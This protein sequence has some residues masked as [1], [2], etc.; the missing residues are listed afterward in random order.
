ML[1]SIESHKSLPRGNALLE[2]PGVPFGEV[3]LVRPEDFA[4]LL[5]RQRWLPVLR[6]LPSDAVKVVCP[7]RALALLVVDAPGIN[8]SIPLSF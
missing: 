4:V 7:R 1:D 6:R 8:P 5:R 2:A 3:A